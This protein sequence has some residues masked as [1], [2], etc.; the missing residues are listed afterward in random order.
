MAA[1]CNSKDKWQCGLEKNGLYYEGM[2]DEDKLDE[3]LELHR[4]ATVSTFGTRRSSRGPGAVKKI[5]KED[6]ENV[7]ACKVLCDLQ[8]L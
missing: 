8:Y 3:T 2:L 7:S 5:K 1:T 4:R 6:K